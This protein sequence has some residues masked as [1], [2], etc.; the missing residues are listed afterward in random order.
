MSAPQQVVPLLPPPAAARG[1]M[2]ADGCQPLDDSSDADEDGDLLHFLNKP[3][4]ADDSLLEFQRLAFDP[5]LSR[6]AA[7]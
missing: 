2:A 6:V 3:H 5:H 4:S 7:P 1:L